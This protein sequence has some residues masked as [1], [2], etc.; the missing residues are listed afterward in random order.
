MKFFTM[1]PSPGIYWKENA[2]VEFNLSWIVAATSDTADKIHFI[3][4]R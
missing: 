3:Q 1:E 4:R 2:A